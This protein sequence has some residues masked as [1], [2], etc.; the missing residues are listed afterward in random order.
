MPDVVYW[1]ESGEMWKLVANPCALMLTLRRVSSESWEAGCLGRTQ[2]LAARGPDE[3]KA[4]AERWLRKVL[5][6][7]AGLLAT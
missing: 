2:V 3:A 6:S 7:L 1:V 5:A 4:E